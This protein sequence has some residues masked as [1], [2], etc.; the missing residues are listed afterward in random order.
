MNPFQE[1]LLHTHKAELANEI[2]SLQL[3]GRDGEDVISEDEM[4]RFGTVAGRPGWLRRR[5][6][7]IASWLRIEARSGRPAPVPPAE[8]PVAITAAIGM[9]SRTL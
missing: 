6:V 3:S 2:R 9:T 5:V 4:L 1:S 7:V 8:E